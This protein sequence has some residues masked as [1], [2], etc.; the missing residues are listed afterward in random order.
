MLAA[1]RRRR[2]VVLTEDSKPTTGGIAEYL[3]Q[4]AVA[5]APTCDVHIVSSVAGAGRVG[6]PPGVSYEE[7]PWYRTQ[8]VLP[9]DRFMPTRRFNTL[10]WR[11]GLRAAMRRHLRRLLGPDTTIVVGRVSAVTDPWCQACR[12]LGVP[13]VAIAHGLELIDPGTPVADIRDAS[14]W[15]AVSHGTIGLLTACGVPSDRIVL[16][17]PGVDPA[18]VA[19]PSAAVRRDVR[20]AV[21]VD[22]A[23]FLL[24]LGMLRPRKGM[25]L[26]IDAF[27]ALSARYPTLHLV[28]AGDGPEAA[29]LRARA[30]ERVHFTGA[31]DD[32]TRNAL[33][34]ECTVFVLA[35]RRF[36]GD[37]EGFGIVFLEAAAHG[38]AAVGGRNGGVPDA[39]VDGVTGV[40]VDTSVDAGP[41]TTALMRLLD[42]P[43]LA[44]TMGE[45]GRERACTAFTWPARAATVVE[46][47]WPR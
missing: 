10:R 12:D 39:V 13:Y 45:R 38:K 22:D 36:P 6:G 32:E 26:A 7:L 15:F 3:H 25:D 9:G 17:P 8:L 30:G 29:A 43:E 2:I 18:T 35:N 24:T 16:L 40:L 34:A 42:E 19:S 21:G 27:A 28:I 14:Q 37:V 31:I 47:L 1:A 20:A 4:L 33:L 41:L 23:P 11:V 46:C 44:R 5:L